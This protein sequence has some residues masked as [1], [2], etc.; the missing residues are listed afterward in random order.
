MRHCHT[1]KSDRA[2]EDSDPARQQSGGKHNKETRARDVDSQTRGV[3]LSKP[4]P[5]KVLDEHQRAE[6]ACQ[7]DGEHDGH[8]TPPHTAQA[9]ESPSDEE[10]ECIRIGEVLQHIDQCARH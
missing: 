3:V 4:Q 8:L 10:F 2:T 1:H 6:H 5:V 9:A 7:Q